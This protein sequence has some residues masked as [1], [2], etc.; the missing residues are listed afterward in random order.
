MLSHSLRAANLFN[1]LFGML[2]NSILTK[3]ISNEHVNIKT[4][5]PEFA[6]AMQHN[7]IFNI[8]FKTA[9]Y[10]ITNKFI[11]LILRSRDWCIYYLEAREQRDSS[12]KAYCAKQETT[13]QHYV[14]MNLAK[15]V[16]SRSCKQPPEM[17]VGKFKLPLVSDTGNEL[18]KIPSAFANHF[19]IIITV[20]NI[21]YEYCFEATNNE[22]KQIIQFLFQQ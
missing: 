3:H 13:N 8:F 2:Y 4:L 22:D 14:I 1:T 15:R 21:L 12:T 18:R 20:Q 10:T 5:P 19:S 16:R 17:D 6:T 11:I 9:N 7:V